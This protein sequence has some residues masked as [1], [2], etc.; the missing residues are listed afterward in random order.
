MADKIQ[1]V[2]YYKRNKQAAFEKNM[3]EIVTLM[4]QQKKDQE[5]YL[6]VRNTRLK[7]NGTFYTDANGLSLMERKVNQHMYYKPEIDNLYA[8]NTYPI[9][10]IVLLKDKGNNGNSN[11]D[12]AMISDRS[13]GVF[14]IEEGEININIDRS[15][16]A[17]DNLGLSE[18]AVETEP[19]RITHYLVFGENS[20]N[21]ARIIQY[22][23]DYTPILDFGQF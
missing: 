21:K 22:H 18:G 16:T 17:N 3:F 5:R 1:I 14:G 19:L 20:E 12:F 9:T 11:N 13:Q 23:S 7:N 10:K 15:P 2:K 8:Q 6:S 4:N